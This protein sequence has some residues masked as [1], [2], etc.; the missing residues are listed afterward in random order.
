MY[1]HLYAHVSNKQN[2]KTVTK[3]SQGI[4]AHIH[5]SV[6]MYPCVQKKKKKMLQHCCRNNTKQ[7]NKHSVHDPKHTRI[8]HRMLLKWTKHEKKCTFLRKSSFSSHTQHKN[9]KTKTI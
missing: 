7:K 2:K 9:K 5:M 8:L 1:V 4:K 3:T 6:C